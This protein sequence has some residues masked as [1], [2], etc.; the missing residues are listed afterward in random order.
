MFKNMGTYIGELLRLD[1]ELK[2]SNRNM[3]A[4]IRLDGKLFE[5][6]YTI[7]LVDV[8]SLFD[9]IFITIELN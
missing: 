9:Q 3:Y 7:Y 4:C 2:I 6:F 5:S 8:R 1:L